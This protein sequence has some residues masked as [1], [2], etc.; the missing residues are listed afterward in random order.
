MQ[1]ARLPPRPTV[2]ISHRF[3]HPF[4][5][6]IPQTSTRHTRAVPSQSSPQRAPVSFRLLS[7]PHSCFINNGGSSLSNSHPTNNPISFSD[8][9]LGGSCSGLKYI[10]KKKGSIALVQRFCQQRFE[11]SRE[12]FSIKTAFFD[13]FTLIHHRLPYFRKFLRLIFSTL[14]ARLTTSSPF[15]SSLWSSLR[16][17][18]LLPRRAYLASSSPSFPRAVWAFDQDLDPLV[19]HYTL[20]PAESPPS[21]LT[22]SFAA[23]ALLSLHRP[24]RP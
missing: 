8:L 22:I 21:A 20:K 18:P 17:P 12:C 11:K 23:V 19:S 3:Q 9:L 13:P 16:R 7:P 15:S 2:S 1:L 4:S 14:T 6:L 24:S 10:R 5:S